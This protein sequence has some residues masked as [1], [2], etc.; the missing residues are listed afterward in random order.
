MRERD[1]ILMFECFEKI[2][3]RL[4]RLNQNKILKSLNEIAFWSRLK[5]NTI[6][7]HYHFKP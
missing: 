5:A 6:T 4:E 2:L 3:N 7:K 1:Q